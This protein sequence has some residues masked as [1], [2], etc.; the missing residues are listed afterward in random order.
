MTRRGDVVRVDFPFTDIPRA[1]KR[2]AVI[3]QNDRDNQKIHKTVV[4]MITGNLSRLG[5]PSHLLIDPSTPDGASSGLNGPSL[6]SCNNLYTLEQDCIQ[7]R[8]GH[9]S[10][11]LKQKLDDCLRSALELS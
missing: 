3:V 1:K 5:D 4:A 11:V 7:K 9:L 6:V 10:D 8:L 2:P